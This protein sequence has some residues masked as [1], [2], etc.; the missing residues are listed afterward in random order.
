[1]CPVKNSQVTLHF[2]IILCLAQNNMSH[3]KKILCSRNS[4]LEI[5]LLTSFQLQPII[6]I[7]SKQSIGSYFLSLQVGV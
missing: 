3:W 4:F 7:D 1:M 5:V 2:Y 6:S